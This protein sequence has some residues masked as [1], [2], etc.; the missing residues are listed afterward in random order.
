MEISVDQRSNHVFLAC[1]LLCNLTTVSHSRSHM[2]S[3]KKNKVKINSPHTPSLVSSGLLSSV[4]INGSQCSDPYLQSNHTAWQS[5]QSGPRGPVALTSVWHWKPQCRRSYSQVNKHNHISGV[6]PHFLTW[7]VSLT[8][9]FTFC[10]SD[11]RYYAAFCF[12]AMK[13]N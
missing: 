8:I 2:K 5:A 4:R 10:L 9:S 7:I 12:M 6:E 3:S 11:F 1:E 13:T